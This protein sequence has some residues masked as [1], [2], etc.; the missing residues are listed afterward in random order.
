MPKDLSFQGNCESYANGVLQVNR[1]SRITFVRAAQTYL[2]SFV[3]S[4]KCFFFF[5]H[6]FI[7]FKNIALCL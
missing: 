2:W 1:L 5:S 6:L 7:Y 3:R 4:V